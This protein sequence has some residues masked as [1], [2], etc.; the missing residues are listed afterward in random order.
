VGLDWTDVRTTTGLAF[1][2]QA[3]HSPP[4]YD[5]SIACLSGYSPNQWCQGTLR[6]ASAH[7]REV[8][9]HLRSTITAHRAALYEI[10]IT[11]NNG[12]NIVRWNG[13]LN[14]FDGIAVGITNNV[15][16]ANGAVWYAQ[17]VGNTITVKCNGAVVWTGSD[18]SIS[19]GSPGMG[20]YG[21]LNAGSPTGNNTFGW[22]SYSAGQL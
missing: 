1:G 18:G 14:S 21:D 2:T 7:S 17:I 15:S 13:P 19:S 5:D 8:E 6:N 22:S 11:Q 9:L 3:I 12:L 20:F 10:D 16:V 4:P